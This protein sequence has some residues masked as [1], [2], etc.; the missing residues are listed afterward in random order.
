M[1][2]I[3]MSRRVARSVRYPS[4]PHPPREASLP[5]LPRLRN[6]IFPLPRDL[7]F[8]QLFRKK[9]LHLSSQSLKRLKFV[10][11]LPAVGQ[12]DGEIMFMLGFLN[13]SKSFLDSLSG[14]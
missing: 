8:L 5:L 11:R 2:N 9:T 13:R 6:P 12:V 3:L 10:F 14:R 7:P 1:F 4:L